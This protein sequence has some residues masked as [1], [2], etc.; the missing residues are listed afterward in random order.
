MIFL[1]T[2]G[3]SGLGY[4]IVDF[5]SKNKDNFIYTTYRS[6]LPNQ[7]KKLNNVYLIKASFEQPSATDGLFDEV[8]NLDFLINNYHS[9]YSFKH[10]SKFK[11]HEVL[12][13]FSINISPLIDI[14]NHFIKIMKKNKSGSIISI[15]SELTD[16]PPTLGFGI[17]TAEKLYLKT[18]SDHWSKE[19]YSYNVSSI[20]ISPKMLD[21]KFNS[22]I[23]S[24]YLEIIKKNGGFSDIEVVIKKIEEVI[25]DPISYNGKNLIV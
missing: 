16:M 24:R 25:I 15:L 13:S 3:S 23:D 9:G 19:L 6:K 1:V 8:R 11:S 5:L 4:S 2:G 7:F 20:N 17:Y 14:N 18:L 12:K 21:T 10:T 22:S